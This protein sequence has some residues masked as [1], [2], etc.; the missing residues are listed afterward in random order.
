MK[1]PPLN[2]IKLMLPAI[3]LFSFSACSKDSDLLADYVVVNAQEAKFLRGQVFD[4][5][6]VSNTDAPMTLD[7][8]SNDGIIDSEKVKIV[9]ISTP[10]SGS[11]TVNPDKTLTYT[12]GSDPLETTT[13]VPGIDGYGDG[14]KAEQENSEEPETKIPPDTQ[15]ETDSKEE[16][17]DSF[18]YTTETTNEDNTTTQQTGT[19]TV[20][21]NLNYGILKA[22]P[23]AY[24]AGS[25]TGGARNG[26][27]PIV[28]K[29]TNLNNSGTG[30]FRDAVSKPNRYI[31]FDVSGTVRLTSNLF[32]TA[33]NLTIAGQ[34]APEGGI[35][36]TGPRIRFID[37]DNLIVRYVRFRPIWDQSKHDVDDAVECTR[38]T[39]AI[40][41]HISVSWGADEAISFV[42]SVGT[43]PN[44][45]FASFNITLQNS[46]I[47]DSAK[48]MI[49]GFSNYQDKN[50]E[51]TTG[52]DFSVN[53]NIFAHCS[54]RFPNPVTHDR[55]DVINNIIHDWRS[56]A[57]AMNPPSKIK[58][59]FINNY[60]QKGNQTS[61]VLG[62]GKMFHIDYDSNEAQLIYAAGN[63]VEGE[64]TDPNR[65]N[66]ALFHWWTQGPNGNT[67]ENPTSTLQVTTA[68]ASGR[69]ENKPFPQ[70][71]HSFTP[72]TALETLK[73]LP[74][75]V[76]ACIVIDASGKKILGRDA[77]DKEFI[78]NV[79]NNKGI[80]HNYWD[81]RSKTSRYINYY[82]DVSTT[83]LNTHPSNWD[84]DND[85][86]PDVWEKSNF[87]NL[88]QTAT[89]DFDSDGYQNIEQYINLVD[90]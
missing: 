69:F 28:Y 13:E 90:F 43:A 62:K 2:A 22:F 50:T 29:V 46:F 87:G 9:N 6:F 1:I 64:F 5:Y 16:K 34:T 51:G 71:N 45:T 27:K 17:T 31:V 65:N 20:T 67:Q 54:H 19:V 88:L 24:G 85:G 32:I 76:G 80:K 55:V 8:L 52:G 74:D 72:K 10:S 53:N 21:I 12:P 11:V 61:N 42:G 25:N 33:D 40:F 70:I 63:I 66:I 44:K 77:I 30:S 15:I 41:D 84:T 47:T 4:D 86:M 3:V 79:K 60:Y 26:P 49:V 18:E 35:S 56:K 82:N 23:T 73:N 75:E 14:N 78:S 39:N 57:H 59:N 89:G 38:V 7:V 37:V 68:N 83:P 81:D 36:I 58:A 48:G